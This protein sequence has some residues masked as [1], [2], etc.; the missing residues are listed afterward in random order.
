MKAAA[1]FKSAAAFESFGINQSQHPLLRQKVGRRPGSQQAP[2]TT[3]G[4][5]MVIS[6]T[7]KS[8]GFPDTGTLPP[9]CRR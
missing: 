5:A 8:A 2:G 4:F 6:L 1:D 9:A 7:G 3:T